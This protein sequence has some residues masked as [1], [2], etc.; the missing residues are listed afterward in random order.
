MDLTKTSG[1][2]AGFPNELSLRELGG[3]RSA[4][5]RSV[6]HGLLYRG[7]ALLKLTDEQKAIVDGFGLRFILDLRAQGETEGKPDYVPAGAEYLR[8][9]GMR[10][11]DGLEVDFSPAGIGRIAEKI[12]SDPDSFMRDLYSSMMFDNPAVHELVRR[13]VAGEAPLYFHCS[14]GKDRTGVCA[15]VL[16][17][18]LGVPDDEIIREFLLTNEY[19]AAIIGLRPEELPSF[20]SDVDR[21]NW[22]KI[23]SVRESDLRAAL[24]AVDARYD[25]RDAY[26]EKEFGLDQA[27]LAKVRDHYLE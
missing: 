26:L 16:L 5:G 25:S 17:M 20:V 14:A 23:N 10:D 27:L 19:R 3:M 9:G 11:D 22:G 7:S 12:Q 18:I 2:V 15:A 24:E 21:E 4:D 13:F 1:Y 6:R 8:I